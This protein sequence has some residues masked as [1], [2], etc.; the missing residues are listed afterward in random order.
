VKLVRFGP[1]GREKPGLIAADGTLRDLSAHVA[2]IGWNEI[3]DAGQKRL[4]A[5][6]PASLP[7]VGQAAPR[8]AL[9][10]HF[11]DR[12]HRPQL[13]RPRPRSR[14]AHPGRTGDVHEGHHLPHRP[15]RRR[16]PADRQQQ[17]RLRGRTRHRHRPRNAPR[18]RGQGARI[19]SPAI[20]LPRRLRAR[21]PARARRPVGQGQG[22][23][24]LRPD[25][26]LAGDARRSPRPAGAA[27]VAGL[28]MASACR[29]P[30]PPT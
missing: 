15:E 18:R 29:I 25:R 13:P 20:A 11:Q 7:K 28:S 3:S 8:R 21:L 10:R 5:I 9:H 27:P 22:L 16:H 1:R 24:Q 14:H 6:D 17:A 26:P 12:R 23:R 2:D 30:P 4:R 19:T